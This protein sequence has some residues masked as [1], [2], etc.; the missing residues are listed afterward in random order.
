LVPNPNEPDQNADGLYIFD[1]ELFTSGGAFDALGIAVTTALGAYNFGYDV[2]DFRGDPAY[3]YYGIF[4]DGSTH[5][6]P[7]TGL[8]IPNYHISVGTASVA[9]VPEPASW[10]MMLVGFGRAGTAMRRRRASVSVA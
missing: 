10:A 4:A 5:I 1:N 8:P 7:R 3:P 2:E 6:S 9:A